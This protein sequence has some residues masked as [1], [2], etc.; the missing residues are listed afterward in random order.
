M[1]PGSRLEQTDERFKI[2]ANRDVIEFIPSTKS[3]AYVVLHTD[4]NRIFAIAFDM[5]GLAFRLAPETIEAA[6]A[7]GG[8]LEPKVGADWVRFSPFNG[9]G[10][11]GASERLTR[12]GEAAFAH[13]ESADGW[14]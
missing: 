1:S 14:H 12:W 10:E 4:A 13:A 6:V 8:T 5:S 9:R 7:D 3:F 2:P 11:T